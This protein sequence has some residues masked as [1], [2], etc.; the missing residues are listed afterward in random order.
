MLELIEKLCNLCGP[1]GNED[2]VREFILNEIKDYCDAYTDQNGNIIAFKKGK[3][4]PHKKVMV[5]AHMDEVGVLVTSVTESGMLR[6]NA[7]GGILTESLLGATVRF[8]N[9]IGV[10]GIKPVHLCEKD[11]K[12]A[13][14]KAESLLIDIGAKNKED[15]LKYISV[16]DIGA[17]KENFTVLSESRFISKAIDDRIGCAL[18]IT[19]L[20]EEAEYDFYGTFTVGEELG[21]R[22]AKTAAFTLSPDYA[23]VLE[24][25]TAAD[26]HSTPE[27]QRVC[28]LSGGAVISFMDNS[29]LYNKKLIDK[30]FEISKQIG[31]KAQTKTKV[32]GGNNSGAIHLSKEGV[33]T[34]TISLPCRYIHSPAS[35]AD[36]SD[37]KD[38]LSISKELIKVF[39]L[40]EA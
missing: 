28:E 25:T 6:F 13:L 17:F 11:E 12:K 10:I 2:A 18:L 3:K 5:D 1:S 35:V 36:I 32:A 7:V 8:E 26:I 22:G 9:T 20:K 34:I 27:E 38:M 30:A 31:A 39:A 21:L 4:F 29:T 33:K 24:A 40:G 16:G 23:I 14:P 19:L 15:A 37:A